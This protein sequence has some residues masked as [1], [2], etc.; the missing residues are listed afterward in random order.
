M[1]PQMENAQ[2]AG[3]IGVE[4][5]SETRR[6]DAPAA[7][8]TITRTTKPAASNTRSRTRGPESESFQVLEGLFPS[9][10]GAAGVAI[11]AL[12]LVVFNEKEG[13][14]ERKSRLKEKRRRGQ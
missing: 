11:F 13:E 14:G 6:L 10:G 12:A 9:V 5:R 4:K 1:R 2:P 8:L 3:V 7:T